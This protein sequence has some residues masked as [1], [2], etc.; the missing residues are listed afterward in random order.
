[1][2]FQIQKPSISEIRANLVLDK[3]RTSN[4]FNQT[5]HLWETGRTGSGKTT[6]VNHLFGSD[7]LPSGG[8]QDCTNEINLIQYGN[9]LNTYDPPGVGSDIYLENYNRVA[10]GIAQKTTSK[11]QPVQNLTVAK[12]SQGKQGKIVERENLTVAN[13]SKKYPNPDLIYYV[14]AADKLFLNGDRNYLGDLLEHHQNIIYVLNIFTDKITGSYYPT[15]Q[16]IID[17]VNNIVDLHQNFIGYGNP[18][19]VPVN[20]WTGEG[21]SDLIHHSYQL[22]G[23]QKGKIFSELIH[24]QQ[25]H[26]PTRFINEIK[27]EILKLSAHIA[28]EEPDD[29]Y[30]CNQAIHRASEQ[31]AGL[32]L[33]LKFNH[34]QN[35]QFPQFPNLVKDTINNFGQDDSYVNNSFNIDF[36]NCKLDEVNDSISS[37]HNE[38]EYLI[39]AGKGI[40]ATIGDSINTLDTQI[41]ILLEERVTQIKSLEFSVIHLKKYE[42]LLNELVSQYNLTLDA[43]RSDSDTLNSCITEHNFRCQKYEQ[44]RINVCEAVDEYNRRFFHNQA[45]SDFIDEGNQYLSQEKYTIEKES[46]IIDQANAEMNKR[47]QELKEVKEL[48]DKVETEYYRLLK[49]CQ[50]HQKNINQ[51]DLA[52]LKIRKIE[53]D[54][55]RAGENL[56]HYFQQKLERLEREINSCV[57]F[58]LDEIEEL[59]NKLSRNDNSIVEFLNK[60]DNFQEQLY[61][62]QYQLSSLRFQ[63]FI[64]RSIIE[65]LA[66]S[67]QY[68]FDE[69]DRKEYRGK[70]YTKY[71]KNGIIFILAVFHLSVAEQINES[72]CTELLT[73]LAE[74]VNGITSLEQNIS[75]NQVLNLLQPQIHILFNDSLNSRLKSFIS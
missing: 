69:T 43:F 48:I 46:G 59:R 53:E 25:Q 72:I 49:D 18:T 67:T 36:I 2:L 56:S 44:I 21:I 41:S 7:Y 31:I 42:N 1:M 11:S 23:E 55:L 13:F 61:Q 32:A 74:R 27:Q 4:T 16:N 12:Y 58:Q 37:L 73:S 60:V 6:L 70:T 22:L 45:L 68:H 5:I 63:M 66:D 65:L 9:G 39:E 52:I 3:L 71:C 10:F 51:I 30:S 29:N 8:Q 14:V 75:P 34:Q 24:Y 50:T 62:Y 38:Y 20:C 19:I 15:E 26:T 28:C 17:V 40:L 54:K 64:N 33:Q 35:S 57:N 47:S